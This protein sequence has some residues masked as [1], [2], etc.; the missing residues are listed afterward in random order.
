MH[1]RGFDYVADSNAPTRR[2]TDDLDTIAIGVQNA[3]N[4][5]IHDIILWKLTTGLSYVDVFRIVM[6]EV[7]DIVKERAK[8]EYLVS[9][10]GLLC[11]V[12][13]GSNGSFGMS[14][15]LSLTNS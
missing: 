6:A 8:T 11:C 5:T 14:R 13:R 15:A 7:P 12:L 3:P 2:L 1:N 10:G 4:P 9:H